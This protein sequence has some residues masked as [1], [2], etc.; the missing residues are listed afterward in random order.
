MK[1]YTKIHTLK[2]KHLNEGYEADDDGRSCYKKYKNQMVFMKIYSKV[3]ST[4]I[5][6]EGV[7]LL[8]STE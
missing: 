4:N 7:Q 6:I 1:S 8:C 5:E 2:T 3:Q